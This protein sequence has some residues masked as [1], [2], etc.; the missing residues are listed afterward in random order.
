MS[1]KMFR[2]YADTKNKAAKDNFARHFPAFKK[3]GEFLRIGGFSIESLCGS[4]LCVL[5]A[6]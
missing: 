3:R 1:E 4:C 6:L 5:T 2:W